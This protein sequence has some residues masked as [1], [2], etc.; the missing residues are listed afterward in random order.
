M[1]T[2]SKLIEQQPLKGPANFSAYIVKYSQYDRF[3]NSKYA[4]I[5]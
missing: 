3:I 5:L 1:L 4:V 2:I